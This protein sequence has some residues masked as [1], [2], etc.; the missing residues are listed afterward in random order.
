MS[1]RTEASEDVLDREFDLCPAPQ[2]SRMGYVCPY[3]GG[4][5]MPRSRA[6]RHATTKR[7]RRRAVMKANP[8]FGSRADRWRLSRSPPLPRD[9][10]EMDWADIEEPTFGTAMV[11]QPA[12]VSGPSSPGHDTQHTFQHN[13][14]DL[15][16]G[17]SPS[18][19]GDVPMLGNDAEVAP[20]P[21]HDGADSD[22]QQVEAEGSAVQASVPTGMTGMTDRLPACDREGVRNYSAVPA[23][24]HPWYP[25]PSEK[26]RRIAMVP[27]LYAQQELDDV[28]DFA[29]ALGLR[30]LPA[31]STVKKYL[32]NL[33]N[34]VPL[35]TPSR[36]TEE[37]GRVVHVLSPQNY[38]AAH[39]ASPAFAPLMHHYP[40]LK[41]SNVNSA[42]HTRRWLSDLPARF[43]APMARVDKVD[44]FVD[45]IVVIKG[46]PDKHWFIARS[47]SLRDEV[48]AFVCLATVSTPSRI[49]VKLPAFGRPAKDWPTLC[50][51]SWCLVPVERFERPVLEVEQMHLYVKIATNEIQRSLPL[52]SVDRALAN[53]KLLLVTPLR[54]FLDDMAATESSRWNPMYTASVQNLALPASVIKRRFM[55]HHTGVTGT[56]MGALDL[57]EFV[58]AAISDT[59]GDRPM[60]CYSVSAG[61]EVLVRTPLLCSIHDSPMAAECAAR[62]R[63]WY[64]CLHCPWGGP[65]KTRL[66]V[67]Q[68]M[69]FFECPGLLDAKT[70]RDQALKQLETY[71]NELVMVN[72]SEQQTSTGTHDVWTKR[73]LAELA[74]IFQKEMTH[75]TFGDK[76]ANAEVLA[77]RAMNTS[78][79]D[80]VRTE[81]RARGNEAVGKAKAEMVKRGDYVGPFFDVPCEFPLGPVWF[82]SARVVT[83]RVVLFTVFDPHKHMPPDILHVFF[84]G[85]VKYAWK[86]TLD[87]DELKKGRRGHSSLRAIMSS[88]SSVGLPGGIATDHLIDYQG[89]LVGYDFVTLAQVMP[90]VAQ[91]LFDLKLMPLALN[92]CWGAIGKLG[93][94]LHTSNVADLD[95]YAT[96]CEHLVN[97]LLQASMRRNLSHVLNKSKYHALASLVHAIRMFGPPRLF[98]ASLAESANKVIRQH[99][100]RTNHLDVS[101]DIARK[102]GDTERVGFI[103]RGG[104]WKKD[105]NRVSIGPAARRLLEDKPAMRE[106]LLLE[107][108]TPRQ[109]PSA[110]ETVCLRFK[111]AAGSP[112]LSDA[113]QLAKTVCFSLPGGGSPGIPRDARWRKAKLAILPNGDPVH[114][115]DWCLFRSDGHNTVLVGQVIELLA[116]E[117]ATGRRQGLVGFRLGRIGEE[118]A[119]TGF[120]TLSRGLDRIVVSIE[121]VV[122]LAVVQHNCT[123][124][125][126]W[127]NTVDPLPVRTTHKDTNEFLLSTITHRSFDEL[128]AF[129]PPIKQQVPTEVF[130]RA[131]LASPT[132]QA[133]LAAAESVDENGEEDRGKGK[134]KGK[135][136]EEGADT[137]SDMSDVCNCTGAAA[138]IE[139]GC[140]NQLSTNGQT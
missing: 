22:D 115:Q 84:L 110:G 5:R 52:R 90:L 39:F 104:T 58:L 116:R 134:G 80:R 93:H 16:F 105:G 120:R 19:L 99:S 108:D 40:D 118:L 65:L 44:Y 53:G 41:P 109:D 89:S 82:I 26:V 75:R 92:E 35:F 95:T 94:H 121:N 126:C 106:W 66:T 123:H 14:F 56:D 136:F 21:V 97:N 78:G 140:E 71:A 49:K 135:G 24:S 63:G 76:G 138:L 131:L 101:Q 28:L 114:P 62:A 3:C 100:M 36:H 61:E 139:N 70:T 2:R 32:H 48:V 125:G 130:V 7:H 9:D 107:S 129:R 73:C 45:E 111:F 85:I 112:F 72:V 67:D 88:M 57:A 137:D 59:L 128:A 51:S 79:K 87:V 43:S 46:V 133:L 98:D 68:M 38:V 54:L 8:T 102:L 86:A 27:L 25:F 50:V 42:Y 122:A 29:T 23:P 15:E 124:S 18:P 69:T 103:A 33:Q 31:A 113:T 60:Q 91:L 74:A 83:R 117:S 47:A 55:L 4:E 30:N 1:P 20:Q 34:E 13:D 132:A 37:R 127:K 10:D 11:S 6:V 64:P 96:E 12:P 17:G 77:F 119:S 81:N